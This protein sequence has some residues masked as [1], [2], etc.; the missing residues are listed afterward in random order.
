MGQYRYSVLT[1]KLSA[2]LRIAERVH[3]VAQ[4][5]NDTALVSGAYRALACTFFYLGDFESS[6]QYSTR[7]VQISGDTADG[8]PW[9]EQGLRDLRATGTVLA[10]PYQLARKAEAFTSTGSYF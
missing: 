7:A 6:R 8:I 1:D 5:Q 2:A 4:E 3:S 9:I 10:L